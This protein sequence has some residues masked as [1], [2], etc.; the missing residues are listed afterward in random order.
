MY[1]AQPQHR[2]VKIDKF[3]IYTTLKANN[4]RISSMVK[5]LKK[6]LYW[7]IEIRVRKLYIR[8]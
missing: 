3:S 7:K 8:C 1:S 6:I 2:D 4:T 5:H